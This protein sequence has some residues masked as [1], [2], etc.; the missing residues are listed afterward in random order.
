MTLLF[1]LFSAFSIL[2]P[3]ILESR[4][5]QG[6]HIVKQVGVEVMES[7]MVRQ[8]SGRIAF[9]PQAAGGGIA[10]GGSVFILVAILWVIMKLVRFLF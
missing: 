4:R 7:K 9:L 1:A 2:I 6:D 5:T 8:L 3:V 10:F